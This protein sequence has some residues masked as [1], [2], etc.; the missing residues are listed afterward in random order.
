MAGKEW[1]GCGQCDDPNVPKTPSLRRNVMAQALRINLVLGHQL[2]FPP[3]QGGGVNNLLW[4]L[5]RKFTEMGHSITAYS[6]TATGLLSHECDEFNIRHVRV[7]GA[8]MRRGMWRNN[9][10]GFPYAM[11]VW[12]KLKPADVTSFHAPF[13]FVLQ[14]KNG[15]GVCTHTIH[16]SPKWIIRLYRKMDR[17]YAGSHATVAEA[18]V[19]A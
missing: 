2:P 10:S 1:V 3:I 18:S 12:R 4:L 7:T 16:R 8:P 19:I 13:S 11:R 6:P 15:I 5:A 17:I 9:V 14:Y